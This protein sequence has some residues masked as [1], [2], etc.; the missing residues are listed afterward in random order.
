MSKAL[1]SYLSKF[2]NL[3]TKVARR[4][5]KEYLNMEEEIVY[6]EKKIAETRGQFLWKIEEKMTIS[7]CSF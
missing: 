6:R 1:Y 5:T 2:S 7:V 3:K 4:E